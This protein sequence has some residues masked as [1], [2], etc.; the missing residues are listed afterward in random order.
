[1]RWEVTNL[2]HAQR[3]VDTRCYVWRSVK[4]EERRG[5]SGTPFFSYQV[6]P[7]EL[8]IFGRAELWLSAPPHERNQ[9]AIWLRMGSTPYVLNL[10]QRGL[11]QVKQK[12]EFAMKCFRFTHRDAALLIMPSISLLGYFAVGGILMGQVTVNTGSSNGNGVVMTEGTATA[13]ASGFDAIY[14][15]GSPTNRLKASNNG[16]SL[17]LLAV[18]PCTFTGCMVYASSATGNP[19][20]ALPAGSTS[21]LPLLWGGGGASTPGWGGTNLDIQP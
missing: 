8:N 10:Q 17:Q 3:L 5:V 11:I 19:E 15:V 6:L 20:T 14:A 13:P 2:S 4:C 18:W 21:G 16:G 9:Y 7:T 12:E 1:M